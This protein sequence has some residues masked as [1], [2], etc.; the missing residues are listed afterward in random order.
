MNH[1]STFGRIL[2]ILLNISYT[3]HLSAERKVL[4]VTASLCS[5]SLAE[6]RNVTVP[7]SFSTFFICLISSFLYFALKEF[8][9]SGSS[10]NHFLNSLLGT[11]SFSHKSI[12]ASS[13]L[14]PLSQSLSIRI[15]YSSSFDFYRLKN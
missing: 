13:F 8:H 3:Y 11:I 15:L 1:Y 9:F 10:A 14:I 2:N 5:S 12:F 7:F 4:S 6:Y